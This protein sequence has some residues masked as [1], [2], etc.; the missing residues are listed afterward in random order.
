MVKIIWAQPCKHLRHMVTHFCCVNCS[1]YFSMSCLSSFRYL[2]GALIEAR[3]IGMYSKGTYP[4]SLMT[5][6][7]LDSQSLSSGITFWAT[8]NSKRKTKTHGE[9]FPIIHTTEEFFPLF[10]PKFNI[11]EVSVWCYWF[12][13]LWQVVNSDILWCLKTRKRDR[14][15]CVGELRCYSLA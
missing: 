1:P 14:Q 11:L 15:H 7:L 13:Q 5:Y 3:Y 6:T 10:S 12:L 4:T 9:M 8:L 2:H